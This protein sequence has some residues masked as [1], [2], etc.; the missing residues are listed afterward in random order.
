MLVW[1]NCP[2]LDLTCDIALLACRQRYAGVSAIG[3]KVLAFLHGRAQQPVDI[4]YMLTCEAIDAIGKFCFQHDFHAMEALSTGNKRCQILDVSTAKSCG[5][6][7]WNVHAAARSYVV[8]ILCHNSKRE[9]PFFDRLRQAALLSTPAGAQVYW[10]FTALGFTGIV[11]LVTCLLSA[12]LVRC[13][14]TQSEPAVL[15]WQVGRTCM[16]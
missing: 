8:S 14:H 13:Q 9:N 4:S 10:T 5:A 1:T 3:D 7:A 15:F 2:L 6:A 11:V 12:M 16:L